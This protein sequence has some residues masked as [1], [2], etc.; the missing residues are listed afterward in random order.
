MSDEENKEAHP[1]VATEHIEFKFGQ[2]DHK[3]DEQD[4]QDVAIRETETQLME[5]M[6]QKDEHGGDHFEFMN[7]FIH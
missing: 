6:G 5:C 3:M 1:P 4:L 2:D 7:V